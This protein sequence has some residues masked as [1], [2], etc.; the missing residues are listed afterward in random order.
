MVVV[1]VAVLVLESC[2][3]KGCTV[4]ED[5]RGTVEVRND[6][7]LDLSENYSLFIIYY[8]R[9]Y[10]RTHMLVHTMKEK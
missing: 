9:I 5:H 4:A 7:P 10:G 8:Y 1:V 6:R 2:G 3:H